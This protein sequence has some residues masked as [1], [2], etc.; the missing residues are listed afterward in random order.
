MMIY[1]DYIKSGGTGIISLLYQNQALKFLPADLVTP[2]DRAFTRENGQKVF[3]DNIQTVIDEKKDLTDIAL[4]LK[5]LYGD[6]WTVMYQAQP[7]SLVTSKETTTGNG[8]I[9]TK[10]QVAGYDSDT[11]VDD[12][13]INRQ[14]SSTETTTKTNF[15]QLDNVIT[16]LRKSNFWSK[17]KADLN[18][19]L[20]MTIYN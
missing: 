19:Y 9:D 13:A 14:N 1:A 7:D 15:L 5:V 11:M 4:E 17:I 10:N 18:N 6:L 3:A 8:S 2:L 16:Q 20:F 12:N